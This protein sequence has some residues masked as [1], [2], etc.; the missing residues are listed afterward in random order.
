M[1]GGHAVIVI[2]FQ[3]ERGILRHC[4]HAETHQQQGRYKDFYVFHF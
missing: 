3:V 2:K 1:T 4:G